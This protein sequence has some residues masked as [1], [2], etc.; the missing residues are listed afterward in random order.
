MNFLRIASRD[1]SSTLKN[2]FIRVSV[3]AIIIVPLL[4][5]LL[6][7]AAFWD[8]YSKLKSMPVAIVNLDEGTEKDGKQV[9]YG[10]DVQDKLK[11]NSELGWRFVSLE[12][13]ENGV[14]GKDYYG[15]FVIPKDF[16]EK[17][18]S[19][20][21]GKPEQATITFTENDKKNFLASQID[22]KVQLQLKQ[23]ISK[24][25]TEEYTKVAFD[26]LN[27]VKD[28]MS[29][30]ADGSSQVSDGTSKLKD[31]ST[32][33]KAGLSTLNSNVPS[34]SQGVSQLYSGT[35]ALDNGVN[36][37]NIDSNGNPLGLKKG[38]VTLDAGIKQEQ[39]GINTLKAK[40]DGALSAF[41]AQNNSLSNLLSD[42]NV[43]GLKSTMK[44]VNFL[45]STDISSIKPLLTQ[46]NLNLIG[47]TTADAAALKQAYDSNP[48]IKASAATILSTNPSDV[49]ALISG[50]ENLASI[51]K[52]INVTDNDTAAMKK[53]VDNAGVLKNLMVSV[54]NIPNI[55]GLDQMVTQLPAFMDNSGALANILKD[56][57]TVLGNFNKLGTEEVQNLSTSNDTIYGGVTAIINAANPA[58]GAD[59][60]KLVEDYHKLV[61]QNVISM[62]SSQEGSLLQEIGALSGKS[63]GNGS[64]TIKD[65]EALLQAAVNG[66]S[67]PASLL[68]G[69]K[70]YEQYAASTTELLTD[71]TKL[72]QE[73]SASASLIN[74]AQAMLT[75]L[76]N[77]KTNSPEQYKAL[78]ETIGS[79]PQLEQSLNGLK[80]S[81][82]LDATNTILTFAATNQTQIDNIMAALPQL[83][84]LLQNNADKL[85][86]IN[87]LSQNL[88]QQDTQKKINAVM[89]D[90]NQAE[91]VIN[92]LDKAKLQQLLSKSPELI[93]TVTDLENQ[94]KN[95]SDALAQIQAALNDNNI[96]KAKELIASL[97]TMTSGITALNDGINQISNGSTNLVNGVTTLGNGTTE[98]KNGVGTLNSSVPQLSDGISKLT[99]GGTQLDDGLGKLKS[100]SDE[101]TSKLQ[102]GAKTLKDGVKNDGTS[103]ATFV[104]EPLA[105]NNKPMNAIN[106]YG[107]GFTP[108]F[109]PLS[110][111]VG[112]IMMFFVIT[113]KVDEDITA[114][115]RSIVLGKFLS[116]GY[117][118]IM[119]S[120]LVSVVVLCLGLKPDN[121]ML[122]FATNVIM[123]FVYIAIIQCLIFLMGDAGRLLA[124]VFLIL[125]LT[126]SG[127]TFP[128]E[129]VPGLFKALN[130]FMPFTYATS[131]LREAISG[132]D[133]AVYTKDMF[134]LIAVMIVFLII[135]VTLKSHADKLKEKIQSKKEAAAA[136]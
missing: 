109:I 55:D 105:I 58:N 38:T 86:A 126:S 108:Y 3:I 100:G 50:T 33:L 87:T 20:K 39:A 43:S 51:A 24:T 80:S 83:K 17:I 13:A 30:A 41:G 6:Y 40:L 130:P 84:T 102:D 94:M 12:H 71:M 18:V 91:V 34:L 98:L 68:E 15:M 99:D 60:K 9:N 75:T 112:A 29:Q 53:V 47:K 19:A 65:L 25:I 56:S 11:K 32:Q 4:Y 123:S 81:G 97:P 95:N 64:T 72:N 128:L 101:L 114:S 16:S 42:K 49:K 121:L 111:W 69:L 5:S 27:T 46:E 62:F 31:G 23:E 28:G 82:I 79:L 45:S 63:D 113:D 1:I 26:S 103:M 120:M 90:L 131:A 44:D 89:T 85:T 7:L 107:T 77:L 8:P 124:I 134:I 118:G 10:E 52:T 2:R 78:K 35:E 116:Y 88:M 93:V 96:E 104:S 115:S 132:V 61:G 125:Q 59:M 122:Y 22:G 74:Q 92:S 106:N 133:Y 37:Q 136:L 67:A 70:G 57:Q 135:S 14:K 48:E 119:Q 127:G 110:L 21:D 129:L 73:M 54:Q 117:I 76:D 66:G 36:N